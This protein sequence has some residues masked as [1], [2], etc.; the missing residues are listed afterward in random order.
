ME[1]AERLKIAIEEIALMRTGCVLEWKE[2]LDEGARTVDIGYTS[3]A[4][5]SRLGRK[6]RGPK[7]IEWETE[8]A[9]LAKQH[10]G[11]TPKPFPEEMLEPITP[12]MIELFRLE[13]LQALLRESAINTKH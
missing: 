8:Q 5:N 6:L 4:E 11:L 9:E 1:K 10:P 3:M 12:E 7:Q 2:T 13:I